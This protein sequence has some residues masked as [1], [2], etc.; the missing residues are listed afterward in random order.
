MVCVCVLA[1]GVRVYVPIATINPYVWIL[2]IRN[3]LCDVIWRYYVWTFLFS[4]CVC[5]L[6]G[7]SARSSN[8]QQLCVCALCVHARHCVSYTCIC[9]PNTRVCLTSRSIAVAL[10][11]PCT[12]YTDTQHLLLLL[13]L[14]SA[15]DWLVFG[16]LF[17]F[18]SHCFLLLLL[19]LLFYILALLS[20]SRSNSNTNKP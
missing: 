19:L 16:Q 8:A 11:L 12:Q 9:E 2:F 17:F 7:R 20:L 18:T 15:L 14:E 4:L 10:T 6:T 1:I 13:F 5:V 3:S